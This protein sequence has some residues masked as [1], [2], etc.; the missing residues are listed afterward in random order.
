[1]SS[2][3]RALV[4]AC[5]RACVH[6]CHLACSTPITVTTSSLPLWFILY[7]LSF[8]YCV[9]GSLQLLGALE[10]CAVVERIVQH[11]A[12]CQNDDGGFGMFPGAESH[13]GQTFCCLA[14]LWLCGSIERI[15][16][17][18]Q[19]RHWLMQRQQQGGG[20]GGRPGKPADT[21]YSWWI[22]ASLRL[23]GLAACVCERWREVERSRGRDRE[24]ERESVCARVC[25]SP[26]LPLPPFSPLLLSV[27]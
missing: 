19:L 10:G 27:L 24:I 4:R 23:I 5:V 9:V 6:V 1:M 18:K 3:V 26:L 21:C 8:T 7:A 2:P 17:T 16:D 14:S 25:V 15:D 12:A 11:V 13:G 20:F 22:V